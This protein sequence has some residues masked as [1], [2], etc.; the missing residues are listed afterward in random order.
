MTKKSFISLLIGT[1]ISAY[2]MLSSAQNSDN[3]PLEMS[4]QV[5]DNL[6]YTVSANQSP[7]AA[8]L[9]GAVMP[10]KMVNLIAQMPGEVKY[11]A[12]QEGDSFQYGSILVGLDTAALFEKRR[13]A[14]A[15]YNSATAGLA[16]A[17]VQYRREILSPNSQSNSML[18][19]A[20]SMFSIFSDPFRSITGEGDP[21]YE[22]FSNVY[23]QNIQI[24]TA[25]NQIEQALA[26]I[27][28]IDENIENTKSVAPYDGVI[29][30]KMVNV[31]DV[32]QPG[33][34]MLVYA[35]TSI[36][37]IQIEVPARLVGNITEDSIFSARLDGSNQL[38]PAKVFRIFPMASQGGHT[39][40]VKFNLPS[41]S[42][43][44]PGMYAEIMIPTTNR[45]SKPLATIPESAI[46]WRGSLPAVFVVSPDKTSVKMRTLRLG[47]TDNKG[48][49]TVLSG[50]AIGESILNNPLASTRSGP[51]TAPI[52]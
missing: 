42:G 14:V 32:V 4:N 41:N 17:Q 26:G 23:G 22:R 25:T 27:R 7:N 29:V 18:G 20:P 2:S 10:I 34:P 37:Q 48:L 5:P 50:V 6:I 33:M 19:G 30:K 38:I 28:E 11:I 15:G 47:N 49:V 45:T 16:N 8:I 40:T 35:D 12:G 3:T 46:S 1:L 44:R 13:A 51:Y 24:Q 9:G 43:A 52:Q 39:I 36:M 21:D 31:G